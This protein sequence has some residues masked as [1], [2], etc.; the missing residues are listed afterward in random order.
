MKLAW[1][2]AIAKPV[3][4]PLFLEFDQKKKAIFEMSGLKYLLN[5]RGK[6]DTYTHTPLVSTQASIHRYADPGRASNMAIPTAFY[7]FEGRF[8]K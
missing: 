3:L 5:I 6:L 4:S 2:W 1:G 8:R 7:V